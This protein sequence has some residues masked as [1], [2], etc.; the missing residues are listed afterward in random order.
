MYT[1]LNEFLQ[2]L[3]KIFANVM[4]HF[5]FKKNTKHYNDT[6][7]TQKHGECALVYHSFSFNYF[8]PIF[9]YYA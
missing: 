7:A 6:T 3:C 1:Y 9:N 2:V 4:D 8:N 5:I